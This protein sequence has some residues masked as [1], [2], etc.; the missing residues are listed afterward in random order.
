MSDSDDFDPEDP[1]YNVLQMHTGRFH[2]MFE[3]DD[4]DSSDSS[5]S[6]AKSLSVE[7]AVKVCDLTAVKEA[8]RKDA[9]AH[10]VIDEEGRTLLHLA[11]EYGDPKR[12]QYADQ[13]TRRRFIRH[14]RIKTQA[15]VKYVSQKG[16]NDMLTVLLEK[17]FDI[18]ARTNNGE[19]PLWLAVK[20]HMNEVTKFLV[21]RGAN[22]TVKDEYGNTL[23]HMIVK[24]EIEA[25]STK[26]KPTP[27][28]TN[29]RRENIEFWDWLLSNGVDVDYENANG[30]TPFRMAIMKNL[31][32][33][34]LIMAKYTSEISFTN[35]D[36][37]NIL[38]ILFG[39]E[40]D[41][42]SYICNHT[43][44][45]LKVLLEK[46]ASVDAVDTQGRTPLHIAAKHRKT[47]NMIHMLKYFTNIHACNEFGDTVLHVA[48]DTFG[49]HSEEIIRTLISKGS[50]I[51][52]RNNNGMNPLQL[53]AKHKDEKV[54]QVLKENQADFSIRTDNGETL[55]HIL[56]RTKVELTSDSDMVH[57]LI[58]Q[59]C[60]VNATNILGFT[61]LHLAAM[62]GCMTV[63]K[64]LLKYGA[65]VHCKD[66]I[67]HMTPL[68]FAALGNHEEVIDELMKAKA[69]INCRTSAG[70]TPLHLATCHPGTLL[71][72][73]LKYGAFV[74]LKDNNGKLPLHDVLIHD[75]ADGLECLL[76]SGADINDLGFPQ[77]LVFLKEIQERTI[78]KRVVE[79]LVTL[80]A[81]KI[82]IASVFKPYIDLDTKSMK[83]FFKEC[84]QEIEV[85]KKI[86]IA[87]RTSLYDLLL[88]DPYRRYSAVKTMRFK[89]LLISPCYFESTFRKY[90]GLIRTSYKEAIERKPLLEPAKS[91]WYEL[92]K[93]S[94]PDICI[95][96]IFAYL[97]NSELKIMIKG[98]EN[99]I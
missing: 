70:K 12:L 73:L 51:Y 48:I 55:L 53:A 60:D 84:L 94:L 74:D 80:K 64:G 50:D 95:E 92:T 37:Q 33:M 5:S 88:M 22:V 21:Q 89:V 15:K 44:D 43:N 83:K 68:H 91:A 20:N 25:F 27:E 4:D 96:W 11:I 16:I 79:H 41:S 65:D 7:E 13:R 85:M 18:N 38:H 24:D 9:G 39:M 52:K 81:A 49:F 17:E 29:F 26:H 58:K 78:W 42:D 54:L 75:N 6:S 87:R 32:N 35:N 31:R 98:T 19:T 99:E 71:K 57:L 3:Y 23:A 2:C 40:S 76:A 72:T 14:R 34:S 10:K 67:N 63:V 82:P 8:L 93:I 28:F 61:P 45:I 47:S 56:S 90:C 77:Q 59:G 46:G 69:D 66:S 36:N 30:D 62:T 97:S 86:S 1:V